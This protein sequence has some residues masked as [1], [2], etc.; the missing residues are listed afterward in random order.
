MTKNIL[1]YT[2]M[3]EFSFVD[4]GTVAQYNL[5]RILDELGQTVRIYSSSGIC[6]DNSLF[7]KFY[8]N[9]FPI[10]DNC[11]VIYC[12]GTGGNPLNAKNVVRW[13]LSEL[14][15]NVPYEMVHSWG[16]NELV[17]YFNSEPKFYYN[18]E[19]LGSIYKFLN[20]LYIN[21]CAKQI[22]FEER[23]GVCYTIRKAHQIH[24]SGFQ[25]VHPSNSFEITRE[26]TQQQCIEFFNKY[27]WVVC[28]D[29]LT[30]YVVIAALCGCIPVVYKVNGLSK[31]EW[32]Q[33]TAAAE[34][35]KSKGLTNLYGIAYGR[36]DME[37][38]QDTIHL[39]KEQW[40]DI[41]EFNKEK[42]IV[43]FI[44]DINDFDN[45]KNTIDKNYF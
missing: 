1:I 30:F 11:V 7:N 9:D 33:T 29:S 16:K 21:P 2:H 23:S 45:M 43:S 37:Y 5:A 31:Q 25:M 39:V 8:R 24:K 36:E 15:Q 13:M 19:K 42:T 32:I 34:Y 41:L 6:I 20:S 44:N 17:Y 27:K 3:R 22:N 4:G 12:E 26:H 38:A 18:P 40:D 10:D 28:Y 35:C 14:G